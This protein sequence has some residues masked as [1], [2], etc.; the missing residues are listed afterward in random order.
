ML[1]TYQ[2]IKNFILSLLSKK[3]FGVRI[4]LIQDKKVLLVKHSYQTGWY[5]IGGGVE[6]GETPLQAME[7]ELKEEVGVTLLKKPQLFSVYHNQN[8]KRDDYI[9]FYTAEGCKQE[10]VHSDEIAEQGWFSLDA[11]PVDILLQPHNG[12]FKS[13]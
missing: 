9:V 2:V 3:T 8:E 13:I 7:R 4:L 1:K 12:A 5:T 10:P 6:A 11:L